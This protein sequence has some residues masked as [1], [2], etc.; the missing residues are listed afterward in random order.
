[1]FAYFRGSILFTLLCVALGGAYG[2]HESHAV[3]PTMGVLWIIVV[4]AVLEISLSFDNAVVNAKVLTGMD[5][6][7]KRRFLTWGMVFAVFGTRVIFPL[8]IVGFTAQLNPIDALRLSLTQPERYEEIVTHA[9]I[10]IA[11]FGGAFLALVGLGF[12][13]DADKDVHWLGFIER[14][15]KLLG[16]IHAGEIALVLL[17]L[18]GIAH[19]L[20][21]REAAELLT[22]GIFGIVTFLAVEGVGAWF[23]EREAAQALA[24]AVVRSGLGG[25]VYLNVLDTSFSLDG[26][27]GAFA[28]TNN[29]VIIALGLSVGAFYVRSLTIML[30]ERGTLAQYR[31]LEHGAFWAILALAGIMLASALVEI[32]ETVTGLVGAGLIAAAIGWSALRQKDA[33]GETS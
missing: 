24:G 14:R 5:E 13:V 10:A 32:P 15:L 29:M 8:A 4:L 17:V 28:L 22:A 31:Y 1:M 16:L 12:F 18:A 23:E 6:V 3:A 30:V 21:A 26:V 7:W 27:I 20:P 2:W 11:G 33:G 9:H 19:A 25:F